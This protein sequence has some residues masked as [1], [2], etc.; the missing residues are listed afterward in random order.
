VK[1]NLTTKLIGC[2]VSDNFYVKLWH[3]SISK[4]RT[5][6]WSENKFT[7]RTLYSGFFIFSSNKIGSQLTVLLSYYTSP[8]FLPQMNRLS[9]SGTSFSS[10]CFYQSFSCVNKSSYYNCSHF[11]TIFKSTAAKISLRHSKQMIISWR[12]IF[13]IRWQTLYILL[14]HYSI[15][16]KPTFRLMFKIGLFCTSPSFLTFTQ[17]SVV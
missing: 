7:Q 5:S 12:R 8:Y 2:H 15:G 1:R 3:K 13:L 16:F 9:C 17:G 14:L 10:P 4:L 11:T 6:T